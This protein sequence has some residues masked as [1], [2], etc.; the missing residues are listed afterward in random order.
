M[1][2]TA[3]FILSGNAAVSMLLL[4]RNLLVARLIPVA[5]YGIAATFAITMAA[6][7]MM[8]AFGLQ[9]QIVQSKDGD[10]PKFQAGLQ[11]FQLLRGVIAAA[12][13]FALA[14]PLANFLRT[15]D[16]AWAYRVMAL[17]PLFNALQHFD[18][19]RLNRQMQ[20]GPMV[21]TGA[22]PALVSTFCVVPLYFI[23]G[24]YQ[25]M[26][27]AIVA[28]YALMMVVSHRVARR[29]YAVSFDRAIMVRSV[30]FGWPLLINGG[31][32]FLV[33][34]ADKLIVGREMGLAPLAIFAMGVTLTLS[35]SLVLAKSAQNFFLPQL[36]AQGDAGN[37][38]FARLAAVTVETALL[39]G[40]LLTTFLLLL[41]Q[42][43]VW[44][45]LGE[46]YLALVPL[47]AWF[48]IVQAVR[49]AKAGPAIVAMA[50]GYTENA[51]VANLCRLLFIPVAYVVALK[52]G[53][54]VLILW[55]GLVGEIASHMVAMRRLLHAT[56]L[57]GQTFARAHIG[58]VV[59]L[60]FAMWMAQRLGT[61]TEIW[62]P[63]IWE[64][65]LFLIVLSGTFWS[66]ATLRL[67]VR[68]RVRAEGAQP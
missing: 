68:Q 45:V 24:D 35:P 31:L 67:F 5:D 2:R 64:V 13:L 44:V 28:Q 6:V 4:V 58:A 42:L 47:I 17:V 11:G 23:F 49:I 41:G 40:V 46:K 59:F 53:D 21:L 20:F 16:I 30:K 9:Q 8:S 33:F 51:M 65:G 29:P 56:G 12:A 48:A 60:I 10:D 34:H 61:Q 39:M 54:L 62:V 37:P 1:F 18:I 22:V 32:L 38:A 14:A 3:L 25:V 19:H 57:A 43:F 66:F 63:Q 7:E 50:A 26:L 27:W 15:P 55:V 52:T 36:S